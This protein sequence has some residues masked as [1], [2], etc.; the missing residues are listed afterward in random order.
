[1]VEPAKDLPPKQS[2]YGEFSADLPP[3]PNIPEFLRIEREVR[4]NKKMSRRSFEDFDIVKEAIK[5]LPHPD[6]NS[7][8]NR[9]IRSFRFEMIRDQ[10]NKTQVRPLTPEAR[11]DAIKEEKVLST[12]MTELLDGQ[13]YCFVITANGDRWDVLGKR[14]LR[15]S[16]A[17]GL[18]PQDTDIVIQSQEKTRATSKNGVVYEAISIK[19]YCLTPKGAVL[20]EVSCPT[21][22]ESPGGEYYALAVEEETK[23]EKTEMGRNELAEVTEILKSR[24][25]VEYPDGTQKA[26]PNHRP[27]PDIEMIIRKLNLK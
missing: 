16:E 4:R 22:L 5:L 21:A 25:L 18:I 24:Q 8:K 10:F 2:G 19:Q 9:T 6:V 3:K 12:L 26:N 23:V 27:P 13:D 7:E 11:E 17:N 1:M 20:I 15:Q 14:L